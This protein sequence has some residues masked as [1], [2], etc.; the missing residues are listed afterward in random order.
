MLNRLHRKYLDTSTRYSFGSFSYQ[1]S[2]SSSRP[3]RL[4][5]NISEN[6]DSKVRVSKRFTSKEI[7][8]E[9]TCSKIAESSLVY[10]IIVHINQ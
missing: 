7:N 10:R 6:L 2:L 9:M 1:S 3:L 4:T 8:G 5:R